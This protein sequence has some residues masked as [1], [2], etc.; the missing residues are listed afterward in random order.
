MDRFI[1]VPQALSVVEGVTLTVRNGEYATDIRTLEGA[2]VP[3]DY[4]ASPLHKRVED[5]SYSGND[6]VDDYVV[7]YRAVDDAGELAEAL[8][9]GEGIYFAESMTIPADVT[10]FCT[11]VEIGTDIKLTLTGPIYLTS[12]FH[13]FGYEHIGRVD[14]ENFDQL[15]ADGIQFLIDIGNEEGNDSNRELRPSALYA[16]LGVDNWDTAILSGVTASLPEFGIS[17]ER[18]VIINQPVRA[19]VIQ[20]Y[21]NL[22]L[23]E[24]GSLTA[25]YIYVFD[26]GRVYKASADLT[27]EGYEG[28]VIVPSGEDDDDSGSSGGSGSSNTTTERNPDGSTTTTTTNPSTGT[29]TEITRHPDGSRE[30]VETQADGTVTTITTDAAGNRTQVVENTD[31]SSTT[32]MER[33]DGSASTTT[34]TRSGQVEASVTLSRSAV[35]TAEGQAAALPM[36]SVPVTSDRGSAPAV[37]VEL[38]AGITSSKVEIPVENVTPGTVA[39]AV[40]PDGTEA[41]IRTT[42]ST[43]NGLVLTVEDG[44]TVK[45]VDNSTDFSDVPASHW[46]ADAVAFVSA[47]ELFNGTSAQTFSP[48]T[49]I[50]RAQLMT[51]LARLDGADASGADALR[52]GIAWAVESGVSDGRDPGAVISRQQL[53]TMLYRYAGSPATEYVPDYP[54]TAQVAG[55]AVDAMR[56]AVENGILNGTSDGL[57]DPYGTATRS[58]MAAIVMRYY[59][60][61]E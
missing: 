47:R 38:P 34:V 53:V 30:E 18:T 14:Q 13:R 52:Q 37:T 49:P 46:A 19:G 9:A 45:V 16:D 39:V 4:K 32:S 48:S 60:L 20:V 50:T 35:E 5:E 54:D 15:A 43:E 56:W 29:V 7:V 55:Y 25:D 10:D 33:T 3:D 26:G 11:P 6:G 41:V 17:N 44:V 42:Q 22:V 21:G 28:T 8:E 51:V 57:L 2:A 58:Q 59:A 24:G 12:Q 23:L 61:M 40:L 31:G 36:P 27:L 1:S